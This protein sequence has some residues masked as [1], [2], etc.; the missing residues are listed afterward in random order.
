[1]KK[2]ISIILV[3]TFALT[4][5]CACAPEDGTE[6]TLPS[7]DETSGETDTDTDAETE[8][9]NYGF[10]SMVL[11]DS[12]YSN[13]PAVEFDIVFSKPEMAE[14]L[15]YTVSDPRVKVENGKISATGIFNEPVTVTV[16]A[17]SEHF[18]AMDTV[19]V[20]TYQGG[21]SLESKI[22]TRQNQITARSGGD[23][24]NC[25][26]FV[27]DSF[28]N[29]DNY[30]TS[31]YTDYSGKKA[32]T[33]GIS[34]TTTE[35]WQIIS[36]RLVYPYSP[37]AVVIHCG[38]NDIFDDG[39]NAATTSESLKALF[40][41]YH[42][43]MPNTKIYWFSIEPRVSKSF[44]VPK[45]VNETIK[46]FASDKDWLVYIDSASW[47]FE[48]NGTTVK[49]SFF[50]DGIHPT[51]SS[52]SLYINALTSA[53]LTFDSFDPSKQTAIADINRTSSQ[54][55]GD[56]ASSI[57]YRGSE[58]VTEYLITGTLTVTGATTNPHAEFQFNTYK[59]R[60]LIW[61]KDGNG[62]FGVGWALDGTTTNDAN[63]EEFTL[64]TSPLVLEWKLLFTQ[65]NA[66][67][68]VNGELKAVYYNVMSPSHLIL[69]AEH[70]DA[71]FT[72]IKV[73]TKAADAA[74][75]N[76]A[77]NAVSTYEAQTGTTTRVVRV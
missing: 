39:D 46:N 42:K 15:T 69:S 49:T 28:F 20:S 76:Q 62:K 40:N 75:Y 22:V 30:W 33:V 77:L 44:D 9:V 18:T 13:Y 36:E 59:N 57:V 2:L 8:Q 68:Y 64:G 43:R 74:Q 21:L 26:L 65:K 32:L 56:G 23:T 4:L 47:C 10:L 50:R 1:M 3:L 41:T 70:M 67:L 17:K 38:T 25:V 48:S 52:Y 66:Y 29:P 60:F 24:E 72:N 55:I 5:L 6:D 14:K 45:Q 73:Y 58:I 51:N 63:H 19:T 37:K 7:T 71:S 12:I 31:F 53:G 61:D 27:G 34:S 11:P 35:D 54:A 16:R